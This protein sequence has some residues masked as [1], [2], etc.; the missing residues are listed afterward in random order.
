M[1]L[2]H[3]DHSG[4]DIIPCFLL[5]HHII[6]EHASIPA[7]VFESFGKRAVLVSKPEACVIGDVKFAIGISSLAV[8]TGFIVRTGT[9]NGSVILGDVKVN[10]PWT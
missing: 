7:N 8:S 2:A 10:G 4:Q 6:G 3:L 9:M 1:Q 5:H